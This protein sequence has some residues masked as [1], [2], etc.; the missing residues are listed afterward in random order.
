MKHNQS[1]KFS[2]QYDKLH[3]QTA[4]KLLFVSKTEK[5]KLYSD[6]IDYDTKANGIIVYKL[7]D[8]ELIL[9]IFVGNK[10]IPF[11]TIRLFTEKKFAYYTSLKNHNFNIII[12]K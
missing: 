6:L 10:G 2:H 11:S 9:L 3:R 12:N 5:D 7:P 4:G 8:K 1:I